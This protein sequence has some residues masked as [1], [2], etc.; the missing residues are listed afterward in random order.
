VA[1]FFSVFTFIFYD[2]KIKEQDKKIN[3]YQL[4]K[5]QEEVVANKKAQIRGNIIKGDK[6]M[7]IFKIYNSGKSEA[8]NVRLEG[9]EV[10]GIF[11]MINN[12]FPYELMNPQ[13]FTEINMALTCGYP[14][15]IKIKYIWDD[16]YQ[17][18]NEFIQIF[19]L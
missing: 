15:T 17:T 4:K 10:E 18:N 3:E 12:L 1:V 8:R 16:D 11:M 14:S 2:R 5:L 19:T 6:G 13:D 9:F 7:R